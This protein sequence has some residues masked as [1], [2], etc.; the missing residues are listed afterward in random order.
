MWTESGMKI[1]ALVTTGSTA[2]AN[3]ARWAS[4]AR[5]RLYGPGTINDEARSGFRFTAG[6]WLNRCCTFGFEG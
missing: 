5:K 6:M 2:D 1:P 4:R 3:P